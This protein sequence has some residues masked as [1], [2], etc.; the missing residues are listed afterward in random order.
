MLS[1]GDIPLGIGQF[2]KAFSEY[3]EE[4]REKD[5]NGRTVRVW[6]NID[7]K[8]PKQTDMKEFDD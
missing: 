2:G 5:A 7:F 3:F 1:K 4:E 8:R 6:Q